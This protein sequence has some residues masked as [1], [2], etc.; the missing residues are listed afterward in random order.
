MKIQITKIEHKIEEISIK[1]HTLNLF[2]TFLFSKYNN[3]GLTILN[4]KNIIFNFCRFQRNTL[5]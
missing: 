2:Q 1:L 5:A 3:L 4:S